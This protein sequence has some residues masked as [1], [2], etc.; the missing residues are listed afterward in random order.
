[1]H[2]MK[3]ER[4][5]GIHDIHTVLGLSMAFERILARLRFG[6]RIEPLDRHSTL[7]TGRRVSR[8]IGH[9]RDA[10]GHELEAAFPALPRLHLDLVC[11][12]TV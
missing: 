12:R 11:E 9:T 1:M 7:D 5:D 6:R 8:I 10:A 3:R 4:I 2:G